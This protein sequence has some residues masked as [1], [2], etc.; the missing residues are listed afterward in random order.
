[1]KKVK[2]YKYITISKLERLALESVFFDANMNPSVRL[3]I[4]R[5]LDR[6]KHKLVSQT[7]P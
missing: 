5:L 2:K 1:M 7:N 6:S 4:K 3:V